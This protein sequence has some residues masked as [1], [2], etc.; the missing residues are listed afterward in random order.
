[1]KILAHYVTNS[2]HLV[3][4]RYIL[5][6]TKVNGALAFARLQ[7]WRQKGVIRCSSITATLDLVS[8]SERGI[9]A[10]CQRGQL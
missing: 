8:E 9:H 1:M 6:L 3:I 2:E 5:R 10:Q 4:L 7:N